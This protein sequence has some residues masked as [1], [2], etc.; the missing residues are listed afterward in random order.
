MRSR[1]SGRMARAPLPLITRDAV[2]TCTPAARATSLSLAGRAGGL[3]AASSMCLTAYANVCL[4]MA[5]IR[6]DIVEEARRL[7]AAASEADVPVR[8]VGGLAVRLH[9]DGLAGVL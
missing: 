5:G 4:A 9:A 2:E 1:V 6:S 7:T 3:R 8:L